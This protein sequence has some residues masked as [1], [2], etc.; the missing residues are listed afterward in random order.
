MDEVSVMQLLVQGATEL[1]FRFCERC[2]HVCDRECRLARLQQRALLHQLW[3]G[4][5]A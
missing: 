4:V 5:R 3:L 1:T 2:G